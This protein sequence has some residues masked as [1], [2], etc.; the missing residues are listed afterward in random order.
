MY[1]NNLFGI[2]DNSLPIQRKP[3]SYRLDFRKISLVSINYDAVLHGLK[4]FLY[5]NH[6]VSM[7]VYTYVLQLCSFHDHQE[8]G[9]Y[10]IHLVKGF[11]FLMH[12]NYFL[13]LE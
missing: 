13:A 11:Y 6:Y 4:F 8:L 3:I 12:N 2:V 5:S 7:H 10:F 9:D 1:K